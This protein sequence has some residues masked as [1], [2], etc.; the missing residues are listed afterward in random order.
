MN[1]DDCVK[2]ANQNLNC[3]LATCDAQQ[4]RVRT[5]MLWY[6]D[7]TGLYFSI[8]AEKDIYSQLKTNPQVEVCF[9]D[10]KSK[11]M[12]QLRVTGQVEFIQDL[13][14][15]KKL[16]D[17]RP[18]LKQRGLTPQSPSL[19]VFRVAKCV[20]TFWNFATNMQPKQYISFG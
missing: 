11:T 20:A 12:D 7:G 15:K 18:F 4:P 2:F 19:I 1:V 13:E 6:A 5:L 17:A 3:W 8:G 9:F 16:L 10:S 14:V